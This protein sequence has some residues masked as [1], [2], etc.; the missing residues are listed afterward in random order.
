MLR[1]VVTGLQAR[2]SR[3]AIPTRPKVLVV[4]RY[5]PVCRAALE[6]AARLAS[7]L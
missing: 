2:A 6:L 5:S 3:E 1:P 4:I 7:G